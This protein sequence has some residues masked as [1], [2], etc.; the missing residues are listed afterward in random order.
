MVPQGMSAYDA[1]YAAIGRIKRVADAY[2]I[3]VVLVHHVRKAGNEDFLQE[4]SGT[5]GIAGA[6]DA[7]LVLRRPRGQADGVLLVTG[8]DVEE[9]EYALTK[10]PDTSNWLMPDGPASDHQM[11]E[12]RAVLLRHVRAAGPISPAAVAEALS[13]NRETVKKTL[14]RMHTDGQVSADAGGRYSAPDPDPDQT[15]I[16]EHHTGRDTTN[17]P[18]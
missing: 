8:R 9:A 5:N 17:D 6:A 13:M 16:T 4:V 7:T 11:G 2:G 15:T 1:D 18:S 12:T 10:D 14:Q 3:A